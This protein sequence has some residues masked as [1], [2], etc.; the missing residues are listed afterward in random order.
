MTCAGRTFRGG[1]H[2]GRYGY[3]IDVPEVLTGNTKEM[4]E[5][6]FNTDRI[7]VVTMATPLAAFLRVPLDWYHTTL[8]PQHADESEHMIR[9]RYMYGSNSQRIFCGFC[10]TPVTYWCPEGD[11]ES[12]YIN[13]T[14][15]SLHQEDVHDL[16]SMGLVPTMESDDAAEKT[17]GTEVVETSP[18][19]KEHPSTIDDAMELFIR[20]FS[21]IPWF[22]ALVDGSVLGRLTK[23]NKSKPGR[24]MKWEVIEWND[25]D[26][27]E[28]GG[29]TRGTVS[30]PA[31]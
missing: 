24:T 4:P 2:C 6:I 13:V 1:C 19:S 14:L 23:K 29:A 25:E 5:L 28:P 22:D 26:G 16:E 27:G 12:N 9:R 3:S 17:R 21:E 20:E 18:A 30:G 10:G 31:S 8:F 11:E 15:G 7:H